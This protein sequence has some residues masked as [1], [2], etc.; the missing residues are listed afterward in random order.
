MNPVSKNSRLLPYMKF[1]EDRFFSWIPALPMQ[2]QRWEGERWGP[3][4]MQTKQEIKSLHLKSTA[5]Q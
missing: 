4:Q 2:A 3:W 5:D 1:V